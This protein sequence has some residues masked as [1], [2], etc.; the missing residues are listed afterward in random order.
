[1]PHALADRGE[2]SLPG[3]GSLTELQAHVRRGD[4]KGIIEVVERLRQEDGCYG[5]FCD[6]VAHLAKG[7]QIDK[8]AEY[9]AEVVRKEG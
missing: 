8:L 1:M 2:Q 9:I 4:I 7:F 6:H 5:D 3:A